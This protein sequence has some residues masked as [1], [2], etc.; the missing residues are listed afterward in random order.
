MD[1]EAIE[2]QKNVEKTLEEVFDA[3]TQRY[4]SNIKDNESFIELNLDEKNELSK[5]RQRI[6]DQHQESMV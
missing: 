5:E 4:L 3:E 1:F 6:V 2:E